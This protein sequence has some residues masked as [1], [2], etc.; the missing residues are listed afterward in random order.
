MSKVYFDALSSGKDQ[1]LAGRAAENIVDIL[2][3][4][5]PVDAKDQNVNA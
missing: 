1:K 3:H 2:L 5:L 4:S